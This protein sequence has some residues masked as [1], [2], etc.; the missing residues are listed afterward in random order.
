MLLLFIFTI[1]SCNSENRK[2][3]YLDIEDT[4]LLKEYN[5]PKH[6]LGQAYCYYIFQN[7]IDPTTVTPELFTKYVKGG[8][9]GLEHLSDY[10]FWLNGETGKLC[11]KLIGDKFKTIKNDHG[12]KYIIFLNYKAIKNERSSPQLVLNHEKLHVAFSIYKQNRSRIERLWSS[13]SLKEQNDFKAKHVGYN[14]N[15]Q[16]V[17]LRE[18]FSYKF[19]KNYQQGLK[20]LQSKN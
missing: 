3:K 11:K 2:S 7:I 12:K 16:D 4:I 9:M 18:Y 8:S 15:N 13:L 14:F 6:F 10:H 1:L 20:L 17:V 19:E 5:E